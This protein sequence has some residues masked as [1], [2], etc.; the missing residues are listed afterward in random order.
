MAKPLSD[1]TA[2]LLLACSEPARFT[3]QTVRQHLARRDKLTDK[4]LVIE[5][6]LQRLFAPSR[7]GQDVRLTVE[8]LQKRRAVL[9]IEAIKAW[10]EAAAQCKWDQRQ[11]NKACRLGERYS[12]GPAG[13]EVYKRFGDAVYKALDNAVHPFGI[14]KGYPAPP[15]AAAGGAVTGRFVGLRPLERVPI[16]N[17][18][19]VNTTNKENNTMNTTNKE[20][21]TVNSVTLTADSLGKQFNTCDGRVAEVVY[22][23]VT[24]SA[25]CEE[26]IV[27]LPSNCQP[28]K[29]ITRAVNA[30][31]KAA[32]GGRKCGHD[33]V[34]E[35]VP[36]K[37][38]VGGIYV[39]RDGQNRYL[40][41]T[42]E[43]DATFAT[44]NLRTRRRQHHHRTETGHVYASFLLSE[45]DL[46]ERCPNVTAAERAAAEMYRLADGLLRDRAQWIDGRV[47]NRGG[48]GISTQEFSNRDFTLTVVTP[49]VVK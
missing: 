20:N 30:A 14:F 41:T 47:E 35:H 1:K 43:T 31:G 29:T 11:V 27:K 5:Q 12:A 10:R 39:T 44:L 3:G 17:P 34:S 15:V 2:R 26:F 36:F 25:P 6:R 46:V 19:A 13:F 49:R 18:F 7:V 24:A 40:V 45:N 21:N 16:K 32:G 22:H 38:E 48:G 28:D 42:K 9:R 8:R 33:L 4:A 37:L 23:N